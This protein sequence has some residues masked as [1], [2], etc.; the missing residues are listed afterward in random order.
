MTKLKNCSHICILIKSRKL[1]KIILFLFCFNITIS[2]NMEVYW[3]LSK[4][5]LT[6]LEQLKI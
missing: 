3:L 1:E 4:I 2:V 5:L 6:K